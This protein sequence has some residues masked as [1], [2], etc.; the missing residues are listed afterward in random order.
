MGTK[1][2]NSYWNVLAIIHMHI[3]QLTQPV[4]EIKE[5]A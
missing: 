1:E 2:K 5:L 4:K 3:Y